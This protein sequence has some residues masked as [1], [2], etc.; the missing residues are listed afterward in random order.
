[1]DTELVIAPCVEYQYQEY[2]KSKGCRARPVSVWYVMLRSIDTGD[3]RNLFTSRKK[4]EAIAFARGRASVTNE[5]VCL[6]TLADD[7][8][9]GTKD[10]VVIP[11]EN[12]NERL[13]AIE[14][15]DALPPP[16]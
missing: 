1:M 7:V 5:D 12:E 8:E 9:S 16:S 6:R 14:T 4:E 10:N 15:L 13:K 2:P 3:Q 11:G